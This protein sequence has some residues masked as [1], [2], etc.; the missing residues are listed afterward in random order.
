MTTPQTNRTNTVTQT[1]NRAH[2][3]ATPRRNPMAVHYQDIP[4]IHSKSNNLHQTQIWYA[5]TRMVKIPLNCMPSALQTL[6]ALTSTMHQAY[7]NNATGRS[8]GSQTCVGS[9]AHFGSTTPNGPGLDSQILLQSLETNIIP[10]L[11]GLNCSCSSLFKWDTISTTKYW[12]SHHKQGHSK[13]CSRGS[14]ASRS[15]SYLAGP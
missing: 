4:L 13:A 6:P 2:H 8:I 15:S 12:I 14:S 9:L 7:D 10:D 11:P 1:P 3:T 5:N